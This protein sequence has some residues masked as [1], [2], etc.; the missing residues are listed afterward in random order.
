MRTGGPSRMAVDC[1]WLS[2]VDFFFTG[3][4]PF[5]ISTVTKTRRFTDKLLAT[6]PEGS[7]KGTANRRPFRATDVVRHLRELEAPSFPIVS[8]CGVPLGIL[9]RPQTSPL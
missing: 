7:T 1:G 2:K 5:T 3:Q 4:N 8:P 9:Y 6:G